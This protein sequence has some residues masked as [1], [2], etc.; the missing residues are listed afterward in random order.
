M[1]MDLSQTIVTLGDEVLDLCDTC[2]NLVTW[3][4]KPGED[5]WNWVPEE[6]SSRRTC[7]FCETILREFSGRRLMKDGIA[8]DSAL[9]SAWILADTKSTTVY[10]AFSERPGDKEQVCHVYIKGSHPPGSFLRLAIWADEGTAACAT[11]VSRPPILG[12]YIY[13]VCALAR[14]WLGECESHKQ[15]PRTVET[16]LPTRV[17]A[18]SQGPGDSRISIKLLESSCE[19][20]R[21]IALSHCWGPEDRSPL[22]TTKQNRAKHLLDIPFDQLGKTFQDVVTLA[23]GIGIEFVWIDSLC[24]LQGDKGDWHAEAQV[25]REV[26]RNATLVVLASGAS[27]GTEGLF[28]TDRED[29]VRFRLPYMQDGVKRGFFNLATCPSGG[30][31]PTFGPL[32]KRAWAFQ[33]RLLACKFMTFMPGGISW[34]CGEMKVDECGRYTGF[35][36]QE[37]Y[38]WHGMLEAYT[39]KDLTYESDRLEALQGIVTEFKTYHGYEEAQYYSEYGVWSHQLEADMLWKHRTPNPTAA[40][41]TLPTWSWAATRGKKSW[42]ASNAYHPN[43]MPRTIQVSSSGVLAIEGKLSQSELA[44]VRVPFG[45]Y[46]SSREHIY[47]DNIIS[48]DYHYEK[49]PA[50]FICD[51]ATGRSVLGIGLYDDEDRPMLH[52]KCLF[53]MRSENASGEEDTSSHLQTELHADKLEPERDYSMVSR[54]LALEATASFR[55]WALLIEPV[56]VNRYRRVG[57]AMLYPHAYNA[58]GA[59]FEEVNII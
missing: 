13:D 4:A 10:R 17:L 21:Y 52:V 22:K 35:W 8:L 23:C 27:D 20:G 54:Y 19:K 46:D 42:V 31:D 5:N 40:A 1:D 33:E 30:N 12:R 53:M 2:I 26:Y 44:T 43:A 6:H 37:D 47:P 29:L 45:L 39:K 14:S 18:L 24:I 28:V 9:A 41:P 3:M 38:L 32:Q 55:Y 56:G 7:L 58:L 16:S 57:I 59:Q 49:S 15:C 25:M 34:S 50:H 51:P 36:D 48:R 11:L